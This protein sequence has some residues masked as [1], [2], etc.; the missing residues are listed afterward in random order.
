[1]RAFVIDTAASASLLTGLRGETPKAWEGISLLTQER[2]LK[3]EW[4]LAS[5]TTT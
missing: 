5:L 4:M 1:M 2:G 3:R